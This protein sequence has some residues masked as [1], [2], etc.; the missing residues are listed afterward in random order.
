MS[1]DCLAIAAHPDDLEITSGGLI[2]KLRERGYEVAMLDMVAGEAG[3]QGSAEQRVKEAECAAKVLGVS[4]RIN[5]G[6]SDAHLQPD[7]ETRAALAQ[8]IRD[9]KPQ[10]VILPYWEQRH[11]DHRV[12]C[13]VGYDACF[14]AG[15][16]KAKLSGEPHRPRKIIYSTYYATNAPAQ[17]AVDISEQFERKLEAIRCYSSQFPPDGKTNR[18]FIPGVDIF[19]YVRLRDRE[20]GIRIRVDYAEGY[21]QKELLAVDDPLKLG[22]V[23]I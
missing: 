5:L 14:Y 13:E 12:T 8:K 11:P 16:K 1:V 7:L 19:E 15:L 23:S 17:F 4:A 10:L 21:V 18:V 3:T 9:L 6:L 2:A 20:L 22:G